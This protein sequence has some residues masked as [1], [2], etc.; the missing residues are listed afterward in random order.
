MKRTLETHLF[1]G[2]KAF[3]KALFRK[4]TR[5]SNGR[6]KQN[7][8]AEF[9][10]IEQQFSEGGVSHLADLTNEII[11]YATPLRID[12]KNTPEKA[13]FLM[14]LNLSFLS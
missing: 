11:I 13:Y 12:R 3:K 2:I 6:R 9:S 14:A 7:W 4:P 5:T 8:L 1:K 10:V